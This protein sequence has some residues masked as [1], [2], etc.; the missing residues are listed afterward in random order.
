MVPCRPAV[1]NEMQST[2]GQ[3][4]GKSD[5]DYL[6]M[7][8]GMAEQPGVHLGFRRADEDEPGVT[9]TGTVG[10]NDLRGGGKG[11]DI[12]TGVGPFGLPGSTEVETVVAVEQPSSSSPG[13][14]TVFGATGRTDEGGRAGK[15][16]R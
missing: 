14:Y 16:G 12:G 9:V 5:H 6:M 15:Q 13:S 1:H 8:A 2:E 4:K 7:L 3:S 10:V 11:K